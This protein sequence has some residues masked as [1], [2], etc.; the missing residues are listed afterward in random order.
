MNR[1]ILILT[2]MAFA[3]AIPAKAD[4]FYGTNGPVSLRCDS[5][6]IVMKFDRTYSP[7]VHTALLQ[8]LASVLE[9]VPDEHPGAGFV[10]CSLL[11][12]RATESLADSLR[13]IAGVALA[14]P[15]YLAPNDSALFVNETFIAA[16]PG[17]VSRATIDSIC[18]VRHVL[19]KQEMPG[20]PNVFL[21]GN[22]RQ[23]GLRLYELA[24]VYHT[25]EVAAFAH[26]NFH[27]P[28]SKSAYTVLDYYHTEQLHSKK[29]I[30]AFNSASVWDFAGLERPV[31]V[32]VIDD[33]INWQLR[34][35]EDLPATRILAGWD[36]NA[37]TDTS[38]SNWWDSDAAPGTEQA[39]GM[40][41]GGI[42]AASHTTDSAEF[43]ALWQT[44]GVFGL[45]P[46]ATILPV[47]IFNEDGNSG[48]AT[49]WDLSA[50]IIY[51]YD[52]AEV[53]SNSWGFGDANLG[54][55]LPLLDS[56]LHQAP[57]VGRAG[58]GCPVVFASGNYGAPIVQ[59]PAHLPGCFAV[60]AVQLDDSLFD[61]SQHDSTLDVVAPS[62]YTGLYGDV[63]TL[64]Q[65]L[66]WGFNPDYGGNPKWPITWQCGNLNN[67]DLDCRFGGTS[68]ACPVVSGVASLVLARDSML[69]V[70]EVYDILRHSA[71]PIGS[72]IPNSYYGYGRVDAFRAVLSI[73]RGDVDNNAVIDIS[74]L[75]MLI[76]WL[77]SI[78]GTPEPF[79]STKLADC[80]CDGLVDISDWAY[81]VSYLF[82]G[83]PAPVKPCFAY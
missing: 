75:I 49:E 78:P 17:S 51:A 57:I 9:L 45:N 19:I 11:T 52:R 7:D 81:L 69:T 16:F 6:R 27:C 34:V 67:E 77:A 12:P 18:L 33:G 68:A 73:A 50:A 59:Y 48:S 10:L 40:G 83:G 39:H 28:I 44:S 80:D 43:Y 4:F 26:P 47:K 66:G 82:Y 54:R 61:Y 76:E 41:C 32:A 1:T 15:V 53:L 14:E 46:H 13:T 79:P 2:I 29:V 30:G 62:G 21:L 55:Y 70:Y 25:L 56:V 38:D 58:K 74:D 42:I 31:V 63:W 72:P 65:I 3:V 8:Q 24:N 60:G 20:M 36:F 64:D 71:V 23:S 22:T 35:H 37:S 5:N